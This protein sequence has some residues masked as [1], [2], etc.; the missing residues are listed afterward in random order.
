MRKATT[1]ATTATAAAVTA[2]TEFL[3]PW[4][5]RGKALCRA[6]R[7]SKRFDSLLR[8]TKRTTRA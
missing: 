8:D 6:L 4:P 3:R 7:L 2:A 1:A 5:G